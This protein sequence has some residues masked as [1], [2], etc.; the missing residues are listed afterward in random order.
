MTTTRPRSQES[1]HILLLDRL[2]L[3]R[4]G[5]HSFLRQGVLDQGWD[6]RVTEGDPDHPD[7]IPSDVS[8]IIVDLGPAPVAETAAQ[9]TLAAIRRHAGAGCP[10]AVISDNSSA[11]DVASCF[12]A[13]AQ[14]FIGTQMEPGQVI[15]V[16]SFIIGGGMFFP[17]EAILEQVLGSR[18]PIVAEPE[19]FSPMDESAFTL[20]QREV[21]LQLRKGHSNKLIGR[22]LQMCESTVKVHVRQIMRK[23]RVSNR[24]QAAL[25]VMAVPDGPDAHIAETVAPQPAEL[26]MIVTHGLLPLQT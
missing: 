9:A 2:P 15:H 4:A 1:W 6:C 5:L 3:R 7:G 13:G 22:E 12:A 25:Q 21:L 26:S 23:L 24:T 20:R 11:A 19:P 14:G 10:I 17:P 18:D 8:L 16:L